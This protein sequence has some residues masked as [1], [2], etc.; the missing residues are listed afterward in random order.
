M[1]YNQRI[2]IKEWAEDDRPRE[3]LLQKGKKA[4]SDAELIAILISSGN[5]EE[6]AVELSKRILKESAENNLD[7]LA[8]LDIAELMKFKGIGEAKALSIV[9][10]MELSRRRNEETKEERPKITTSAD[11]YQVIKPFLLDL[12]YEEFWV[13]HLNRA[14]NV[15]GKTQIGRGGVSGT[16]ADVRLIYKSAIEHLASGII[17]AHN[18]PSGAMRPS[19]SDINLTKKVK[20]AGKLVDI[21]LL[22]HLIIGDREFFSFTDEGL[23]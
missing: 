10:A 3:K 18:H 16:V 19:E 14:N 17:I 4:L 12:P 11:A 21:V 1:N 15:I 5:D 8:K 23:I 6:S 13:M 9:A 20:D 22:D 2:P 7:K